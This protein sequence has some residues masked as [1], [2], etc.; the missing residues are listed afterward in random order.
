MTDAATEIRAHQ[1]PGG[2]FLSR[3]RLPWGEVEDHNCFVTGL[4]LRELARV[5]GGG[6]LDEGRRQAAAF[7]L[8][9]RYP[10][11]TNLFSF[12][13]RRAHP[14]W[15]PRALYPDADDTAVILLELW[16]AGHVP[17]EALHHAA[18][19]HLAAYRATGPLARHLDRPWQR[20]GVFLTWLCTADVPNPVDCCVNTNVVAMLAACGRTAVEGYAEA[21]AMIC[22]AAALAAERPGWDREF[23]PWYPSPGEWV[24]ALEHAVRAGAC[25]VAPALE[26]LRARAAAEPAGTAPLCCDAAGGITWRADVLHLARALGAGATPA[27]AP[28]VRPRHAGHADLFISEG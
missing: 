16:R 18:E 4:V 10:G 27:A 8:R 7:L 6:P 12:Y 1:S 21:C 11:F 26:A 14:F 13:P 9:S 24:R 22:D 28:F 17:A 19:R 25:E 3:V 15:M 5:P 23:T 2:C 20:Q